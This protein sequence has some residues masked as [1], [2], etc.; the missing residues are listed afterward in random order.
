MTA[1]SDAKLAGEQFYTSTKPCK[2]GNFGPKRTSNGR[3]CCQQCGDEQRQYSSKFVS[4]KYHADAS[5]RAEHKS[6]SKV[7]RDRANEAARAWYA[8][9]GEGRKEYASSKYYRNL[10]S[11]MLSNARARAKRLEIPFSIDISDIVV[12]DVCPVLGIP[13]EWG[14]GRGRMNDHS[15]S[16][17]RVVPE[18]GYVPGNV[19]VISWLAN[20]LK[21][22]ATLEQLEALVTYI[23]NQ[24]IVPQNAFSGSENAACLGAV[25]R[26]AVAT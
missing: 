9:K 23:H 11:S 24:S 1:R 5:F 13:L 14:V 22:N 10:A 2:H 17:D 21:N 3:C 25:I 26:D 15:P 18:L 4:A 8:A 12:P 6:K 16:L 19:V 20:R 7:N